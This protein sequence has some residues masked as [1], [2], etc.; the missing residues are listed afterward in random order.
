VAIVNDAFARRF[1]GDPSTAVGQRLV[2]SSP[3]GQNAVE[4]VGVVGNVRHRALDHPPEPELYTPLAQTFM[5][6]MAFVVRT[7]G[8]PAAVAGAVRQAAYGVD[9]TVPVAEMQ[10]LATLLAE[11]LGRPR[12]LAQLLSVFAAIGLLLGVVG[13]Y[14]VIAH[15]VRQQEREL[16]IRL[17]IGAAPRAVAALVVRQAMAI[18]LAGV[19]VGLPL[20][21]ALAHVMRTQVFGIAPRDPFTFVALPALVLAAALVAS[22]LPARRAARL[23]PA[24]TMRRE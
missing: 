4:I 6:P 14:G 7:A 5:F 9:R 2:V 23:D 24:G 8:S 11:S 10:P 12:L 20:A 17:A 16:G 18:A 13:V 19:A 15:R 21:F 3:G 1:I 22:Y